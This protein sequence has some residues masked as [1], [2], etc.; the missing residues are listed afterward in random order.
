[1][2]IPREAKLCTVTAIANPFLYARDNRVRQPRFVGLHMSLRVMRE[3][4]EGVSTGRMLVNL[5]VVVP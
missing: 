5:R 2:A 3:N 1:M 4:E